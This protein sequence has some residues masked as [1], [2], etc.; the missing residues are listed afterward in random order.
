MEK[1]RVIVSRR[2]RPA[3]APLS[4][5]IIVA[6]ALDILAREGLA[7]LRLR[8]VATALDTGPASLYVYLANLDEMHALML[9]AALAAMERPRDGGWR[10]RLKAVL[11]RYLDVL[12]A[13][14][15][16]AQLALSTIASGPHSLRIREILLGLLKEGGVDDKP[17][18]W[19]VDL[20]ILCVTAIVA[21]QSLH[22][23][24]EPE[25]RG[26]WAIDVLVD[27]LVGA[28]PPGVPPARKR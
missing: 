18:A 22:R 8:R 19:G 12:A 25:G 15:G 17:A 1:T 14:P 23:G 4:R 21:E 27:G 5:E 10:A 16:L 9:D 3:K 13:R 6:T 7:G 26:A 28:P 2:N 11:R 20:L 24:D